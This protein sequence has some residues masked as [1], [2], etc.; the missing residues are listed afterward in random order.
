M[1]MVTWGMLFFGLVTT[2]H[3]YPLGR[4][5]LWVAVAAAAAAL[6]ILLLRIANEPLLRRLHDVPQCARPIDAVLRIGKLDPLPPLIDQKKPWL[7]LLTDDQFLAS[8]PQIRDV[9]IGQDTIID[10][11]MR[12]L[13]IRV[14]ARSGT[15]PSPSTPPLG[16]YLFIGEPGIG[17]RFLAAKLNDHVFN[18]GRFLVYDAQR[19]D[20]EFV[21]GQDPRGLPA[22]L[23]HQPY[24]T[25]VLE[26]V[27]AIP[28][29]QLQLLLEA[30][31]PE[32]GHGSPSALPPIY[33]SCIFILTTTSC[34]ADLRHAANQT[35]SRDDWMSLATEILRS[36]APPFAEELLASCR[37]IFL[38]R[39][40]LEDDIFR[41]V[42][43]LLEDQLKAKDLTLTWVD[44]GMF[45]KLAHEYRPSRGYNLLPERIATL[46][47]PYVKIC[48]ENEL[49]AVEIR[50]DFFDQVR[51]ATV[52][53]VLSEHEKSMSA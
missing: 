40:P 38:F 22:Q 4:L 45:A 34:A 24:G 30:L 48:K 51:H 47:D 52:S 9:V 11:L 53:T 13:M 44:P 2:L 12:D 29:Q 20:L 7:R 39:Q 26:N 17:K 16:A 3:Q 35:S 21:F 28:P 32:R 23:A 10:R 50:P 36:A 18:D 5:I 6:A 41:V 31:R 37:E 42:G 15:I 14:G 1:G 46:I 8:I 25:V 33:Q 49:N 27:E 19:F 43:L